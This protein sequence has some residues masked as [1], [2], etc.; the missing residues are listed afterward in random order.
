MPLFTPRAPTTGNPS[1]RMSDCLE[2]T[3]WI[4]VPAPATRRPVGTRHYSRFFGKDVA[5]VLVAGI[6]ELGTGDQR[7]LGDRFLAQLLLAGSGHDDGLSQD[8]RRQCEHKRLTCPVREID[9]RRISL[10]VVHCRADSILPRMNIDYER[11]LR[12]DTMRGFQP[13]LEISNKD[14]GIGERRAGNVEDSP[15]ER[16][17]VLGKQR[18]GADRQ[19]RQ[20]GHRDPGTNPGSF[21]GFSPVAVLRARAIT[22]HRPGP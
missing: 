15:L 18:R 7:H 21:H 2:P 12:I 10:K 22:L 8:R 1:S 3:P 19:Q 6:P 13:G 17:S 14:S 9:H 5:D 16:N 11:A 4:W 20:D